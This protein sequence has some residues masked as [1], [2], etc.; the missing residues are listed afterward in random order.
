M[1]NQ[2]SMFDMSPAEPQV[3]RCLSLTPPWSDAVLWG[4]KRVE[5]RLKWRGCKYRG[6]ILLHA[7]SSMTKLYYNETIRFLEEKGIEWRP[8]P[9]DQIVSGC[10]VGRCRIVDEI[11]CDAGTGGVPMTLMSAR[12]LT[13][14]EKRWHMGGFAL[15]LS[16]V[17]PIEPIRQKG[18]LGLFKLPQSVMDAARRAPVIN[19]R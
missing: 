7:S 8:P 15:L 12:R 1:S 4:G 18:A 2:Q 3:I 5:N 9:M 17:E 13:D 6:P 19:R 14:D 10:I 16:D 11:Y